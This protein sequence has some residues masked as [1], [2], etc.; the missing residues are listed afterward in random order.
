MIVSVALLLIFQV[1]KKVLREWLGVDL[2]NDG[3]IL[4]L[5]SLIL[6]VAYSILSVGGKEVPG[7]LFNTIATDS[8][9]FPVLVIY[10][11]RK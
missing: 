1:G 8:V 11:R 3:G 2:S 6:V 7:H 10:G 4:G 9:L 5:V